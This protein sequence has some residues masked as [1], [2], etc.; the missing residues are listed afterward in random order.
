MKLYKKT[1][2]ISYI[3]FF[4]V[5]AVSIIIELLNFNL[6]GLALLKDY[7]TGIACSIIVVI[8]TTYLQFK[9]EQEKKL[10]EISSKIGTFFFKYTI[11]ILSLYPEEQ[12]REVEYKRYYDEFHDNTYEIVK[13]LFEIT[14]FSK[15]KNKLAQDLQT[16]FIRFYLDM[17]IGLDKPPKVAIE[18]IVNSSLVDN[19]LNK[20]LSFVKNEYDKE[21]ILKDAESAK[22]YLNELKD[23]QLKSDEVNQ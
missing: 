7:S 14:W 4:I 22:L 6:K 9:H 20:T 11:L 16:D 15:R 17:S 18:S 8:V 19:I 12:T 10:S 23:K 1:L 13:E 3:I 5:F 2:V 21:K